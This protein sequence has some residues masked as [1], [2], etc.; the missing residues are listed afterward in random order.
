MAKIIAFLQSLPAE[1]RQGVFYRD[2]LAHY[3]IDDHEIYDTIFPHSIGYRAQAEQLLFAIF[4]NLQ[5]EFLQDQLR[6]E[7]SF[8]E[9]YNQTIQHIVRQVLLKFKITNTELTEEINV[10]KLE[11]FH[12]FI[13]D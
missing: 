9:V 4:P 6:N 12:I 5:K 10:L 1:Y 3:K 11:D 13:H 2:L 7:G 8:T